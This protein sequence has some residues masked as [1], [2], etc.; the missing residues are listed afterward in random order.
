VREIAWKPDHA[1][2]F[3]LAAEDWIKPRSLTL[4]VHTTGWTFSGRF[5][6][7]NGNTVVLTTRIRRYADGRVFITREDLSL[8]LYVGGKPAAEVAA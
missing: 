2:L 5:G 4:T 1:E 7:P 8:R 6:M 3:R